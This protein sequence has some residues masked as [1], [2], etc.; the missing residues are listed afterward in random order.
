[1][2]IGL[3]A[4]QRIQE[5]RETK[6][7]KK[8]TKI[9]GHDDTMQLRS[10]IRRR[11]LLFFTNR[12]WKEIKIEEIFRDH[13]ARFVVKT[14]QQHT[15]KKKKLRRESIR[16]ANALIVSKKS[17]YSRGSNRNKMR[18]RVVFNSIFFF[19]LQRETF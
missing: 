16:N 11:K 17:V 10:R 1:M 4:Q 19:F 12:K 6:R 18:K 3:D 7:E 14:T 8:G 13:L 5:L 15:A 9:K 2:S